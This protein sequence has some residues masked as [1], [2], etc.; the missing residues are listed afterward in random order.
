MSEIKINIQLDSIKSNLH[1]KDVSEETLKRITK[2][3]FAATGVESLGEDS[4][5]YRVSE[6]PG[7][8]PEANRYNG[9]SIPLAPNVKIP[10]IPDVLPKNVAKNNFPEPVKSR[11]GKLPMVGSERSLLTSVGDVFKALENKQSDSQPEYYKT[12]IKVDDDGT[13]R[14]KVR[15]WCECGGRGNHYVPLGTE[16]VSCRDCGNELEVEGATSFVDDDGIP[17]RDDFGN[18]FIAREEYEGWRTINE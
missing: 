10:S 4:I 17:D 5:S 16:S 14:Y 2:N 11:P 1:L 13:K 8:E 18:F 12:G 9:K 7:D 15:F 6:I 3:F